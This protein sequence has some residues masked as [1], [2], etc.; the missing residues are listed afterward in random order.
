MRTVRIDRGTASALPVDLQDVKDQLRI[1]DDQ[2]DPLLYNIHI[3]AAVNWAEGVMHRNILSRTVTWVISDF[4]RGVDESLRLPLGK[5][6]SVSSIAYT[7]NN[8]TTTLTGPTSGSPVGTDY[9]EDLT[10]SEGGVLFPAY[11]ETWPSVDLDAPQPVV[12]TFS[13]GWTAAQIP[14]QVKHAIFMY[15]ADAIDI[16]GAADV[17]QWSDLS[18][19]ATLLSSWRLVRWP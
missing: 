10:G 5:T 9:R 13:A 6:Q 1:L 16:T 2:F 14:P 8:T 11:N 3:P 19:K 17:T 15:C 12:I 7:Q 4:P 18:A